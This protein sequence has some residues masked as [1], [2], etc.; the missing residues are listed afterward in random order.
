MRK[1]N[2]D[3]SHRFTFNKLYWLKTKKLR[4]SRY[5]ELR[6]VRSVHSFRSALKW[7]LFEIQQ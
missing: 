2:E 4:L 5:Y 6:F 3:S 7:S 1:I